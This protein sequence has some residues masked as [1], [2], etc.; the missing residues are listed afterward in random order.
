[1]FMEDENICKIINF[2]MPYF[3][4]PLPPSAS[5]NNYPF[6]IAPSSS[7]PPPSGRSSTKTALLSPCRGAVRGMDGA[8][9][10]FNH[11]DHMVLYER[12]CLVIL[13]VA[14]DVLCER[15]CKKIC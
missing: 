5:R 15:C 9:S 1:M 12:Y 2:L 13:T 14:S 10:C 11:G 3:L 6:S 7:A 8:H 4:P